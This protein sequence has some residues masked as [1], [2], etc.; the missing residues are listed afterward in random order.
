LAGTV[1]RRELEALAQKANERLTSAL[2]WAFRDKAISSLVPRLSLVDAYDYSASV[3]LG[4]DYSYQIKISLGSLAELFGFANRILS[5]FTEGPTGS[6][7]LRVWMQSWKRDEDRV[8]TVE[9][10]MGAGLKETND[11]V[12]DAIVLQLFH[13][14]A[15]VAC[16]HLCLPEDI[17][18][19]PKERRAM[20]LEA[21]YFAGWIYSEYWSSEIRERELIRFNREAL[22]TRLPENIA[23][24]TTIVAFALESNLKSVIQR[25]YHHPKNRAAVMMGGA[26][27]AWDWKIRDVA[28]SK[29]FRDALG[30]GMARSVEF[31]I[32][33]EQQVPF[34][35]PYYADTVVQDSEEMI[36]KS[37]PRVCA[38]SHWTYERRIWGVLPKVRSVDLIGDLLSIPIL[39]KLPLPSQ[40]AQ[41]CRDIFVK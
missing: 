33:A 40:I 25:T 26:T 31:H 24:V 13:E 7:S 1:H 37:Y 15:H 12:L 21:D 14:V 2:K 23:L 16:A 17:R 30:Q 22:V 27:A 38:V 10:S 8:G 3:I 18:R 11:L 39:D 41:Q 34:W 20:E 9:V 4:P 29:E 32:W 36:T 35:T 6:E 19:D 28:S 5:A